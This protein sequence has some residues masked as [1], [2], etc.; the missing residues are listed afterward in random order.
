MADPA[1][2]LEE[3]TATFEEELAGL[4]PEP[5]IPGDFE[6][7][8][9]RR[10]EVIVATMREMSG[11]R[12]PQAMVRA[13]GRR[14]SELIPTDGRLSLSRRG[15]A[16]PQYRITRYSGWSEEVNPWKSP[17]RLPLLEGGLLAELIYADEPRVLDDVEF[18]PNDPAAE[19]LGSVRS[20]VAIP[21][22][23]QGATLN[24]VV[25][26]R[27][28]PRAFQR[29]NFPEMVWVSNLFGKA[30]SSL[31]MA[32]RVE[33]AYKMVDREMK[34]VAE[35]QH[36]LLPAELPNVPNLGL[37]VDYRTSQRAGGDYYD[38]FP[39]P[40]GRCGILIADV[41][42]HGT[43][44][45][46]VMAITH[47]IAHMYPGAATSPADFL[48][49]LNKNLASRYTNQS[50]T[51]VTAFYG[52]YDPKERTILY[53]SAG[54]NP[55]RLRRCVCGTV[56]SL[57]EAGHL[58]LGVNDDTKYQETTEKLLQGDR[59]LFYTD[60]IVEAQNRAGELFGLG[61]IDEV[62]RN[63]AADAQQL[64]N[65]VL[66]KLD[67]FTE[68]GPASDDRTLLVADIR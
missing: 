4:P 66:R 35:I 16:Y 53:S 48:N 42:G 56:F 64:L 49:F 46:V 27:D 52:I 32:E 11:Q 1:T 61:R 30:T 10:L 2:N 29:D 3:S 45:A 12:D 26:M 13:Y 19:Y 54:H 57:D 8:W 17:E 24:M 39:L 7:D 36:S 20:L 33:A 63:C 5:R 44:A 43:P 25:L 21:L 65:N 41:S 47:T 55:P 37:A 58:P 31:V 50:G 59:I 38:F 22:F 15:L 68:G 9:R 23:D 18:S 62:L 51:F 67:E 40:D 14:I 34:A 6:G 28:E 60:G